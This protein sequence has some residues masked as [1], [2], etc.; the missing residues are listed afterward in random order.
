MG[1]IYP[2]FHKIPI[3]EI[4][5]VYEEEQI[6][7]ESRETQLYYYYQIGSSSE[8]SV[9][10]SEL[11]GHMIE[12]A[13]F[14]ELRTKQQLGYLVWTFSRLESGTDNFGFIIQSGAFDPIFLQNRCEEFLK[15]YVEE[16]E[17]MPDEQFFSHVEGFIATKKVKNRKLSEEVGSHWSEIIH[18]RNCFD[19]CDKAVELAKQL[20]KQDV[21][22]FGHN[23]FYNT[24]HLVVRVFPAGSM[25][26][27][28]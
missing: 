13:A 4:T 28:C 20:T 25:E 26:V 6:D 18:A 1:T 10:M 22:D 7:P 14:D 24:P 12:E 11:F 9:M 19:H 3:A 2:H 21:I 8:R 15:S 27:E 23:L 16:M 17:H 5:Y